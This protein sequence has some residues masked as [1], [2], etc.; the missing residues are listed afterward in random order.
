VGPLEE[1][2][3]FFRELQNSLRRGP[4][5]DWPALSRAGRSHPR[6]SYD[7]Y[8]FDVPLDVPLQG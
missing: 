8:H 4:Q 3:E 2:L 5:W 1:F 6:L 7:I